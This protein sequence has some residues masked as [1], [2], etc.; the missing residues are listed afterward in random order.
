MQKLLEKLINL[1]EMHYQPSSS[2][3]V[4]FFSFLLKKNLPIQFI[5]CHQWDIDLHNSC[6]WAKSRK[7]SIERE[8]HPLLRLFKCLL[9]QEFSRVNIKG[10][11]LEGCR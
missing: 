3:A 1:P 6:S 11:L 10:E 7:V 5:P 8:S 4:F 2:K 9:K